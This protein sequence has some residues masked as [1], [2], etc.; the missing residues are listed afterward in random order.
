MT[1]AA[2]SAPISIDLQT[3]NERWPPLQ[4]PRAELSLSRKQGQIYVWDKI[5]QKHLLLTPEEWVRQHFVH[6]LLDLG[7][8]QGQ[9]ALEA[10]L[11]VNRQLRRTDI[12]VYREQ[13]PRLVVECKAPQ[14]RIT[15]ETFDQASRYNLALKVNIVVVTNGLSTFVAQ[16][17]NEGAGYTLLEGLPG[18]SDL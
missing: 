9:I 7:Y 2:L 10:G 4:L 1:S 15:Q 8:P 18:Y 11:Y 14:V 6:Y 16:R 12:L 17:Q 5:R 3:M 13:E